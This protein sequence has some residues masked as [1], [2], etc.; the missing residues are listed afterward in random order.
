MRCILHRLIKFYI[1]LPTKFDDFYLPL[2]AY[3]AA[4]MVAN[5]PKPDPFFLEGGFGFLVHLLEF[6]STNTHLPLMHLNRWLPK[7][8]SVPSSH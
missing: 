8:F 1:I 3:I 6:A 2:R 7:H 4:I 5:N